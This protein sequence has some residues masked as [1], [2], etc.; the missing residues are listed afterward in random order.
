M[1]LLLQEICQDKL[2]RFPLNIGEMGIKYIDS[3]LEGR[4]G[5]KEGVDCLANKSIEDALEEECIPFESESMPDFPN[6]IAIM[7]DARHC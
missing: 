5:Y 1:E 6:K 4:N 3:L 7:T 2:Q